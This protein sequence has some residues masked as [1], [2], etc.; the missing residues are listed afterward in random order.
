MVSSGSGS[1]HYWGKVNVKQVDVRCSRGDSAPLITWKEQINQNLLRP[2]GCRP[3]SHNHTTI[4]LHVWGNGTEINFQKVMI[5]LELNFCRCAFILKNLLIFLFTEIYKNKIK[6]K[7]SKAATASY[8]RS[9]YTIY[10]QTRLHD[11]LYFFFFV[12]TKNP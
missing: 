7:P 2:N 5:W 6:M 4:L 3:V 10:K 8:T 1:V 12:N 11:N 9:L